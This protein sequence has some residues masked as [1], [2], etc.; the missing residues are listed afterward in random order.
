MKSGWVDRDAEAIVADGVKAGIDPDLSLRVYSSRLFGCDPKLVLHGGGNT[1]L[2]TKMRD[3]LGAE[4][5]VLRVKASGV[6]MA[7]IAPTGFPA[8]IGRAHV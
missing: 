3:A 8:K 6:D 5:E 1:S 4:V 7:S 2:K